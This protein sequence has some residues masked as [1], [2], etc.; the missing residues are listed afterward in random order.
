MWKVL[1]LLLLTACAGKE[2]SQRDTS[3]SEGARIVSRDEIPLLPGP[4]T[5]P[6]QPPV[7]E[8]RRGDTQGVLR[9]TG[10]W[11]FSAKVTHSRLFCATYETG[12]QFGTGNPTC[13]EVRWL[14]PV[15]FGSRLTHCNNAKRIHNARGEFS[16]LQ[17]NLD[18]L[19]C[20][21]V[22]VRCEGS[23]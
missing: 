14:T 10:R 15:E 2:T 20:A 18:V 12:V 17:G 23:C 6:S 11:E 1:P 16:T 5:D 7:M 9:D 21:R 19:T 4:V 8:F 13:T 3:A 22:V